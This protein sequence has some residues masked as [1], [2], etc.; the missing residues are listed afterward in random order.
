ME[1]V[2]DVDYIEIITI[3]ADGNLLYLLD[4]NNRL[5]YEFYIGN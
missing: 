2:M 3:S 5:Y 1:L 4:L